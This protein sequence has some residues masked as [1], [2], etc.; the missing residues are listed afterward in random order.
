MGDEEH[1]EAPLRLEAS[2][3]LEDSGL[4]GGVES[5]RGLIGDDELGIA[6]DGHGDEDALLHPSAE[7][8]G[9]VLRAL[10]RLGNAHLGEELD[11][12]RAGSAAAEAEMSSERLGESGRRWCGP[13]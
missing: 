13:D 9:I 1:R 2:E 8:V 6:G 10:S 3:K 5:G 4:E 12:P 11:G 7:L